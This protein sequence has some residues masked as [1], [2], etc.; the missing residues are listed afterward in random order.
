M[1]KIAGILIVALLFC[2]FANSESFKLLKFEKNASAKIN[3]T[4]PKN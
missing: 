1:N 4:L 2:I 3:K